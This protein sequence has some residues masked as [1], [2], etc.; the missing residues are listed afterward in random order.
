ML[1]LKCTLILV[2]DAS[3]Q[4]SLL[5]FILL[6]NFQTLAEISVLYNFHISFSKYFP[7]KLLK[8]K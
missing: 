5:S 4:F 3:L 2:I 7:M 8:L 1:I 6:L